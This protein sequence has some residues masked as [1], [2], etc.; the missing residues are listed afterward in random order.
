MEACC[1]H[2][3]LRSTTILR[4]VRR[5]VS[6]AFSALINH[7]SREREYEKSNCKWLMTGQK[8]NHYTRAIGLSRLKSKSE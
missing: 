4:V 7:C 5:R 2:D 3:S 8:K 6:K 1:S